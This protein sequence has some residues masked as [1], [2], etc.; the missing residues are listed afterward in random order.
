[1]P[2]FQTAASTFCFQL[3][4]GEP[5]SGG[6]KTATGTTGDNQHKHSS[7][8]FYYRPGSIFGFGFNLG[9]PWPAASFSNDAAVLRGEADE[10]RVFQFGRLNVDPNGP[11][12]GLVDITEANDTLS[13][14]GTL[15]IK[16]TLSSTEAADTLVST[17]TLALKGTASLTEAADTVSATGTLALKG[18]A[19][20]TEAH[21]V[22]A[23]AATLAIK[24]TL[25]STEANATLAATGVLPIKGTVSV[26]E[27][28]D[29][30]VAAGALALKGVVSITL[31]DVTVSADSQMP[32]LYPRRGGW[33]ERQ[34][35]ERRQREW[36]ENLRRII[37]RSWRIANGEIDPITFEPIPLPD[38]SIINAA[39]AAQAMA[40]DRQRAE[41][42]I[43]EAQRRQEDDA[44]AILLLAA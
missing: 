26:T 10:W 30:V 33:D 39:L 2:V 16:G 34:E 43:A 20:I 9:Q 6:I 11:I 25:S 38:Y 5:G 35:F 22:L 29:T 21:D 40:I 44:I 23:A 14:T 19:A 31:G 18:V 13:A 41:A 3:Q 24:G 12:S 7:P 1:M 27:A 8:E 37:D 32:I 4:P 15:A 17:G 42:F 28:D 36:Q